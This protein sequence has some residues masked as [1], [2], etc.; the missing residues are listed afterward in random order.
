M[1]DLPIERVNRVI[2][3]SDLA[4]IM[5]NLKPQFSTPELLK[6]VMRWKEV[7]RIDEVYGDI[8]VILLSRI[9]DF[10][11]NAVVDKIRHRYKDM[12]IKTVTLPVE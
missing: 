12:L 5:L 7:K 3:G 2:R 4:Y 1:V 8:D 6:Q 10:E 9:K 11:G